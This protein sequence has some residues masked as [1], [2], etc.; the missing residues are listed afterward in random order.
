MAA[1]DPGAF[2]TAFD[3]GSSSTG[4]RVNQGAIPVRVRVTTL[5]NE[6]L[7]VDPE[8]NRESQDVPEYEF[9]GRTFRG[10]YTER[11]PYGD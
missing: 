7:R 2:G 9:T 11:G 10:R 1:F 5:R 8:F 4:T 6:V 3:I